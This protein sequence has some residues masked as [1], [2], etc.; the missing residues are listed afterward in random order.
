METVPKLASRQYFRLSL[1]DLQLSGFSLASSKLMTLYQFISKALI[2]A[3]WL[4]IN[5]RSQFSLARPIKN[6]II[7]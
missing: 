4:N 2:S 6:L 7:F 1:Q 5:D 3:I